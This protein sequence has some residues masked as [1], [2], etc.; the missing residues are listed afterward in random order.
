MIFKHHFLAQCSIYHGDLACRNILLTDQRIVKISDFGL[1]KRL[2]TQLSTSP[3][4]IA[5]PVKWLALEVIQ[6]GE[7]TV[8]ADVWSYGIVLWEIFELGK[9]PYCDGKL[10]IFSNMLVVQKSKPT[11]ADLNLARN[12]M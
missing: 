11:V 1:S 8:M 10:L 6:L 12:L 5:Q 9:D 4:D 3:K 2:Y 7:V